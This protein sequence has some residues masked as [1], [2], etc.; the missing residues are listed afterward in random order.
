MK[1]IEILLRAFAMLISN[2]S[3]APSMVRFLNRFSRSC[4]G[5]STD[6]NTYLEKLFH[7]VLLSCD[8][9]PDDVFINKRNRRFN[10]ALFEAAFTAL[11]ERAFKDRRLVTGKASGDEISTLESDP[12]FA[13]ASLQATTTT[14]NVGLRLR[15]ASE[16]ITAL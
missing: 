5:H 14:S 1:D 11:C 7:S 9:L 4:E 3:Y 16:L 2:D 6:Q 12:A 8:Q 10:L 13:G 15:R